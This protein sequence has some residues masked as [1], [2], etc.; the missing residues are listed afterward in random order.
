MVA[1]YLE[2][3]RF[4]CYNRPL[5]NSICRRYRNDTDERKLI[6]M[7]T[8]CDKTPVPSKSS[9]AT[10][11]HG[12]RELLE[13]FAV[14][15][16]LVFTTKAFLLELYIIPTGSMAPTLRGFHKDVACRVCGAP[17]LVGSSEEFPEASGDP[18]APRLVL[19]GVCPQ[20]RFPMYLGSD[21]AESRRYP[22]YKGDRI[23]VRKY[24]VGWVEPTRWDV[25][26]FRYP[27]RAQTN[28]IKRL[29]GLPRETVRIEHG[30]IF[31]RRDGDA[32]FSLQRRSLTKLQA[33]LQPVYDNDYAVVDG[34]TARRWSIPP[35]W[36]A[37]AASQAAWTRSSDGRSFEV[38]AS[39]TPV[40]L[41]YSHLV[42][43][44]SDSHAATQD[45]VMPTVPPQ[46]ITDFTGYNTGIV[47]PVQHQVLA[48]SSSASGGG[49]AAVA[50]SE[51]LAPVAWT[52]GG[53]QHH[54][55]FCTPTPGTLGLNWVGDLVVSCRLTTRS[56]T[57]TFTMTLVKGGT[58]FTATIDLATG[59]ATLA[60]PGV[61]AFVPVS[62]ETPVIGIG[63]HDLFL[64][65]VDEEL[66]LAVDGE[67]IVFVRD[68]SASGGRYDALCDRDSIPSL[69][70]DRMPQLLDLQPATFAATGLTATVSHIKI[71]RDIY[72][73]AASP[74]GGDFERMCDTIRPPFRRSILR[75]RYGGRRSDESVEESL[76]AFFSRSDQWNELGKTHCVEF[77]LG[78]DEFLMLGD[79]SARSKDSRLWTED[80][81]PSPVPRSLLIGEAMLVYWPHGLLIPWTPLALIPN[82]AQMRIIH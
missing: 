81:I 5:V 33:M 60:I 1:R 21:N 23:L 29:V 16:V 64:A 26:V 59:L 10:L 82:W 35:R 66:R 25:T 20:C 50:P 79:N 7:T 30:D 28:Y 71:E 19:G 67:E 54:D 17:V 32:V 34:N 27:A 9:E 78:D 24:Q 43:T 68:G 11:F 77:V 39:A 70:R 80:G 14:A 3:S 53:Q 75:T 52:S 55:V 18:N 41:G 8:P 15:L 31:V 57:G 73:I 62:A 65:N 12:I 47:V 45:G 38:A 42:Q 56:T 36:N 69:R 37:D 22:S 51:W 74:S 2:H 61:E 4:H 13:S 46:L 48:K 58:Q 6:S 44:S 72:Y 63:E 49:M 76:T 40:H